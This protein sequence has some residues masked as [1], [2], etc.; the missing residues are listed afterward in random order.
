MCMANWAFIPRIKLFQDITGPFRRHIKILYMPY[1]PLNRK[2]IWWCAKHC[3]VTSISMRK[4]WK[5]MTSGW[6]K[7]K[8]ILHSM[9]WPLTIAL[10]FINI[11]MIIWERN[12]IFVFLP[13]PI[14]VLPLRTM[15]RYGCLP[16]YF[17]KMVIWNGHINICVFPG[18]RR[19]SIMPVC[20]AG[21]VRMCFRWLTRPTKLWLKNRMTVC[22]RIY[23][24]SPHYWYYWL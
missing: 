11:V 1:C 7:Q 24:L 10:W 12:R 14:F 9:H 6:Q 16:N 22:N 8:W 19:N 4:P 5:W 17:T 13:Y 3:F 18:M 2:N 21:R 20:V 15:P 23:C